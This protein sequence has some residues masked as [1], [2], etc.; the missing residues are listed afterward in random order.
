MM[1]SII[2]GPANAGY[3]DIIGSVS[4]QGGTGHADRCPS[5]VRSTRCW[6]RRPAHGLGRSGGP[7][8]VVPGRPVGRRCRQP[9]PT[10]VRVGRR[11]WQ[12]RRLG[13]RRRQVL[14]PDRHG[15]RP[16]RR[17]AATSTSATTARP[18]RCL[19]SCSAST[20]SSSGRPG[21][22][23]AYIRLDGTGKV[24]QRQQRQQRH[25]ARLL[26]GEPGRD[27]GRRLRRLDDREPRQLHD[28]RP[29]PSP[30]RPLGRLHAGGQ[31][32]PGRP[33][34]DHLQAGH[35]DPDR[36]HRGDGDPD[37]HGDRMPVSTPTSNIHGETGTPKVTLPPTST[38]GSTGEPPTASLAMVFL[39]LGPGHRRG[40]R[41]HG[42]AAPGARSST[43]PLT[44]RTRDAIGRRRLR[45]IVHFRANDDRSGTVRS[46][47]PVP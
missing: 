14:E 3:R 1:S 36:D 21:P 9:T 13:S 6:T 23:N 45:P 34:R 40:A 38:I 22:E 7:V 27:A 31:H 19:R 4:I 25:A 26:V 16:T 33:A 11:R 30:E 18:R 41:P 12:D 29:C 32:R 39:G 42:Q 10:D 24:G 43:R 20:A 5:S 47:T 28:P 2:D 37:V 8:G 15:P 44:P 17:S 46:V 35:A